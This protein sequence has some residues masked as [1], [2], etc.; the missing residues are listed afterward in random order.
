MP[1]KKIGHQ[2]RLGENRKKTEASPQWRGF[3]FTLGLKRHLSISKAITQLFF[4]RFKKVFHSALY[5]CALKTEILLSRELSRTKGRHFEMFL[6][7]F[8]ISIFTHGY[9]SIWLSLNILLFR[10]LT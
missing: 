4:A 9:E 10:K 8:D 7:T 5:C 1:K 2:P 6:V 3:T